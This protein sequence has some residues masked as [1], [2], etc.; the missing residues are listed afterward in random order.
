MVSVY[1][2][3]PIGSRRE[4]NSTEDFAKARRANGRETLSGG[5][6]GRRQIVG[7]HHQ[8]VRISALVAVSADGRGDGPDRRGAIAI[9]ATDDVTQAIGGGRPLSGPPVELFRQSDGT[10]FIGF[11]EAMV[12]VELNADP[13]LLDAAR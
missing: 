13:S 9:D 1:E 4:R 5:K 8:L 7:D 3:I 12:R 11:W 2:P 10:K 6:A